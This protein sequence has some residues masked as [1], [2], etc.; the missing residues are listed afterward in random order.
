MNAVTAVDA[1]ARQQ[2]SRSTGDVEL[3]LRCFVL[4]PGVPTRSVLLSA[5][6]ANPIPKNTA[7]KMT[8]NAH[9]TK[10]RVCVVWP[11]RGVNGSRF[12]FCPTG[13]RKRRCLASR[14][15]RTNARRDGART[16]TTT[17]TFATQGRRE[18][19]G[20]TDRNVSRLKSI[21]FCFLNETITNE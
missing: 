16:T 13:K 3:R 15:G 2:R 10:R 1:R 7:K 6:V 9:L 5:C 17:T 12:L 20:P 4:F 8:A 11:D 21:H 18:G 14:G 19:L